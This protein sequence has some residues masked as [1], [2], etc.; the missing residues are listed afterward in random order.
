M[1]T[2][3]DDFDPNVNEQ[4][5]KMY[6]VTPGT[7]GPGFQYIA[8]LAG[9]T[10]SL[11]D[12]GRLDQ[13]AM[14]EQSQLFV[15]HLPKLV[16]PG[17]VNEYIDCLVCFTVSEQKIYVQLENEADRLLSMSQTLGQTF[18]N[19]RDDQDVFINPSKGTICA[20]LRSG[21]QLVPCVS[22]RPSQS[23]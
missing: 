19:Q 6:Q 1:A 11:N 21:W 18:N 8:S 4:V 12:D 9:T 2:T 14:C 7:G 5:L 15:R 10:G 3:I 16:I 13:R 22:G 23:A 17:G 20:V